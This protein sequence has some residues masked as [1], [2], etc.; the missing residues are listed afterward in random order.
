MT[1]V[2]VLLWRV[3]QHVRNKPVFSFGFD[4]SMSWSYTCE[5]LYLHILYEFEQIDLNR[6]VPQCKLCTETDH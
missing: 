1:F 2:K 6:T 3:N 4:C 5:I